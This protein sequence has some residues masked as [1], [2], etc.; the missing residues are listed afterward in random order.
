M[1]MH[2]I[3]FGDGTCSCVVINEKLS[4]APFDLLYTPFCFVSVQIIIQ[5]FFQPLDISKKELSVLS[6]L[7]NIVT[8][9]LLISCAC[10]RNDILH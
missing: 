5:V 10:F 7:R 4:D 3:T 9:F 8:Q 1:A 2:N 6:H